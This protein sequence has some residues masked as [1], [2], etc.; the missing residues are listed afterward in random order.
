MTIIMNDKRPQ[1]GRKMKENKIGR[2]KVNKSIFSILLQTLVFSDH[3][4]TTCVVENKTLEGMRRI[5]KDKYM[6]YRLGME[7]HRLNTQRV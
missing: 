6:M 1:A 4:K 3:I 5:K 7:L 2:K